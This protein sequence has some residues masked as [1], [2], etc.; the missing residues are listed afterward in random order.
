MAPLARPPEDTVSVPPEICA[1][2]S[3]L[4]EEMVSEPP[5]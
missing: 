3:V 4:P 1:P 2:R 5:P